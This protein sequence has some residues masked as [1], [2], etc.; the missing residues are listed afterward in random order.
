MLYVLCCGLSR[1]LLEA[2]VPSDSV[3]KDEGNKFLLL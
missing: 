1:G 2:A 3:I